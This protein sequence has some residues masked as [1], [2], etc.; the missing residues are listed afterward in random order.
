MQLYRGR[1]IASGRTVLPAA[2][3]LSERE[4]GSPGATEVLLDLICLLLFGFAPSSLK[5][6]RTLRNEIGE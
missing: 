2:A 6:R 5:R 1:Y 4:P 3:E